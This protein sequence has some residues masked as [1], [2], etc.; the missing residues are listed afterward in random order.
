MIQ[1]VLGL[2]GANPAIKLE[3]IFA[4]KQRH[5][6]SVTYIHQPKEK[7]RAT[8]NGFEETFRDK[9]QIT[10]FWNLRSNEIPL[11]SLVLAGL[12]RMAVWLMFTYGKPWCLLEARVL[13]LSGNSSSRGSEWTWCQELW[14]WGDSALMLSPVAPCSKHQTM[15]GSKIPKYLLAFKY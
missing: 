15:G 8:C 2:M 9:H 6:S 7:I 4:V 12:P 5:L 10:E 1:C 3:I 13:G 14:L 11:E